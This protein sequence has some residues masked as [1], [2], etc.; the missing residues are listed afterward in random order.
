MNEIVF[1]NKRNVTQSRRKFTVASLSSNRNFL[2]EMNKGKIVEKTSFA[3]VNIEKRLL[4]L[5][6]D[7]A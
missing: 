6:A 1:P 7:Y 5:V 2:R 3:I 4:V